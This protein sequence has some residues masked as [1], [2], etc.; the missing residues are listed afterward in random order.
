MFNI[1]RKSLF[2]L[3]VLLSAA[4]VWTY[5]WPQWR[6]ANRDGHSRETGLMKAWP[7]EGPK[8]LWQINDLGSGYATPVIAGG[9][10][11]V[12]SNKGVEDEFVSALNVMDGK[13]LWSVR[14]GKVGSPDQKPSFP[15]ARSTPTVDGSMPAM[16]NDTVAV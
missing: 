7:K 12:M 6:G 11:Y 10:I 3:S 4:W 14:V 2:V 8:L 15:A 9:R 16:L 13:T 1:N 5:D